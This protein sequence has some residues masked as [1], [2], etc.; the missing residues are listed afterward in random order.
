MALAHPE[1]EPLLRALRERDAEAVGPALL[2]ATLVLPAVKSSGGELEPAGQQNEDGS[3]ELVAFTSASNVKEWRPETEH[4]HKVLG[5]DLVNLALRLN[6]TT[7]RLDPGQPHSGFLSRDALAHL[8]RMPRNAGPARFEP[9]GDW[10]TDE[11]ADA[12]RSTVQAEPQLV[13]AW[14][15]DRGGRPSV[16]VD[17]VADDPAHLVQA[18]IAGLRPVM[19]QGFA[20]D[21]V[22]LEEGRR[23]EAEA[24]PNR[25]A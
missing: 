25:L 7:V 12:V 3:V 6:A 20:L 4:V 1:N 18:M 22:L 8:S 21:F 5:G 16:V 24:L 11:V 23:A 17:S 15:A 19:P 14:L 10:A 2:T 13:A 9:P